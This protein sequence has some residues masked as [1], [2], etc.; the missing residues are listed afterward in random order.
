MRRGPDAVAWFALVLSLGTFGRAEAQMARCA[1]AMAMVRGGL[2]PAD[3]QAGRCMQDRPFV[4]LSGGGGLS[5]DVE[6]SNR[7]DAYATV[8]VP[9]LRPLW[10]S[11]RTRTQFRYGSFDALLGVRL[12]GNYGVGRDTYVSGRTSLGN[13]YDRVTYT[14]M[15]TMLRTDWVL[16][17]GLRGTWNGHGVDVG[18][19]YQLGIQYHQASGFGGH[20]RFEAYLVD[21]LRRFG[22][23]L[24]YYNAIPPTRSLVFGMEVGF[25]PT[26]FHGR[27]RTDLY[28]AALNLGWSWER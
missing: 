19:T 18:R 1:D 28:W 15:T 25:V 2:Q 16:V 7:L 14:S 17:A 10:I 20:R 13:G 21:R 9:R 8:D 6:T 23:V 4:I 3:E 27:A 5:F 26:E 12:G 22:T 24:A 11:G